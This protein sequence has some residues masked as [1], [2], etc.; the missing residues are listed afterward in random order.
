MIDHLSL[1]VSDIGKARA[2]Y[3]AVLAPLDVKRLREFEDADYTMFGYGQEAAGEPP[4]WISAAKSRDRADKPP[5][6]QH[7]AFTAQ[8]RTAVDA[9]YSAALTAGARDNGRPGIRPHYHEHYYAAFVI[10]PDGHHLEAV[11]HWPQRF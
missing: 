11:C 5:A 10:D 1:A 4:F 2:F 7:V 6:G 8:T 9:F 3:D